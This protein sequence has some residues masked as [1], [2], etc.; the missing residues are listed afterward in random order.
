MGKKWGFFLLDSFERIDKYMKLTKKSF[1][2][3]CYS[4]IL[5][6]QPQKVTKIGK[7][8]LREIQEES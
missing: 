1:N 4:I 3:K 7:A 2:T 8:V 6:L 5:C